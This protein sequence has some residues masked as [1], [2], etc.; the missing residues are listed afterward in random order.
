MGLA[1]PNVRASKNFKD[2]IGED[3]PFILDGIRTVKARTAQ[4]GEGEMVVL[5]VRGEEAEL[6]VWGLYLIAQ[7]EAV[8]KSDLGHHYKMVTKVVPEFS[9]LPV[10]ALVPCNPED[11][12]EIPF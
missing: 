11:G 10:K 1:K 8:E 6:T 12:A 7:A 5:D 9:K 2:V 4:Y 3:K